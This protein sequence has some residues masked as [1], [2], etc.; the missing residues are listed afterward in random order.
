M[1]QLI[2][3]WSGV[4]GSV[5][6]VIIVSGNGVSPVWYQVINYTNNN[7][8]SIGPLNILFCMYGLCDAVVRC[9]VRIF[10]AKDSSSE[11]CGAW[12][13]EKRC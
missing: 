1:C 4:G 2:V 11:W 5:N 12:V 6:G 7:L 9:V 8:L 3:N 10:A 13:Y